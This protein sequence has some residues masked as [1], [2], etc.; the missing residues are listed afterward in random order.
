MM[1]TQAAGEDCE[2]LEQDSGLCMMGLCVLY[3]MKTPGTVESESKSPRSCWLKLNGTIVVVLRV[4]A[5]EGS[6]VA[7]RCPCELY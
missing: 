7:H 1:V 4:Q 2:R 6:S 5:Y 3:W